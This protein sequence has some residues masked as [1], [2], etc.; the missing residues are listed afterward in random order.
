MDQNALVVGCNGGL[1][2]ALCRELHAK[3]W[4]VSGTSRS[5]VSPHQYL[6][7]HIQADLESDTYCDDISSTFTGATINLF[8]HVA[9]VHLLGPTPSISNCVRLLRVNLVAPFV[10]ANSLLG[11]MAPNSTILFVSSVSSFVPRIGEELYSASKAGL[12]AITSSLSLRYSS[13]GISVFGVAPGLFNSRMSSR[14]FSDTSVIQEIE[15]LS[16]ARRL[17]DSKEIAKAML[18]LVTIAPL[19]AGRVIPLDL[20]YSL[21]TQSTRT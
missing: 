16:P 7:S 20:G 14:V 8:I 15:Q 3:G 21:S 1:G 9:G 4:T 10:L 6:H 17:A 5:N 13:H 19:I 2:F 18:S 11:C 12:D